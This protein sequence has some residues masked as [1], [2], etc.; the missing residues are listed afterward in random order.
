MSKHCQ[1]WSEVIAVISPS[2]LERREIRGKGFGL[3]RIQVPAGTKAPRHSHS[4]EQFVQV[5][6]GRGVLE[7]D[8]GRVPFGAGTVFHFPPGVEHAAE[9]DDETVL[10][11]TNLAI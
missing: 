9:F 11:E 1:S 4:F 3:T 10:V 2:G 8:Q 7:T 5:I 6:S